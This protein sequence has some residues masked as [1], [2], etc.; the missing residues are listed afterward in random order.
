MDDFDPDR[1]YEALKQADRAGDVEAARVIASRLR[2]WR[3]DLPR[4]QRVQQMAFSNPAEYMTGDPRFAAK[5]GPLGS[6]TQNTLAGAGKSLV[7]IG[8]GVQQLF[9]GR[10]EAQVDEGR[11]LDAP[12]MSTKAGIGGNIGG[13]IAA[14]AS[15]MFIPGAN[16]YTGA[17]LIGGGLGGA[18]PVGTGESRL[19]NTA[20]GAAGGLAGRY[21]GGK[22]SDWAAKPRPQ[23]MSALL[24]EAEA[25]GGAANA[26]A[27]IQ[28]AIEVRGA[29]G[30]ANFGSVGS[31]ASAGITESQRRLLERGRQLGLNVPPGQASGSRALQQMEAKLES[32]PMT[33]GPFNQ[34][35]ATNAKGI[36]RAF[37]KAMERKETKLPPISCHA[38]TK[39]SAPCS[40]GLPRTTPLCMTTLSK[41]RSPTSKLPLQM[42]S[43]AAKWGLSKSSSV[44]TW[45]RPRKVVALLTD[46]STRTFGQA[47]AASR[48]ILLLALAI[49]LV[50]FAISWMKH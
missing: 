41:P 26:A 47:L 16:T 50:R 45:I 33:S 17:A 10:T 8:R 37:L 49:G 32:Q 23:P 5:Y 25:S 7:D 46:A 13:S 3:D 15:T 1:A 38:P 34:I 12:L 48:G 42:N 29:G 27:G 31:D 18:Q 24:S 22:I 21:I 35:K 11:R 44:R 2:Q 9:G 19:R 30:G 43:P 6:N 39:E 28:G 20:F 4:Q 14:T 36:T 40:S